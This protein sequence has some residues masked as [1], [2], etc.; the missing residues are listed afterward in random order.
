[1]TENDLIME[2][3]LEQGLPRPTQVQPPKLVWLLYFD[4]DLDDPTTFPAITLRDQLNPTATAEQR[5]V[6]M[7][8]HNG[9]LEIAA[10]GPP[11]PAIIRIRRVAPNDYHYW[12]YR[13]G[14]HAEFERC[15]WILST[16]P[17]PRWARGRRWLII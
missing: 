6:V 15:D 8:H 7:H 5:A 4:V 16:F 17:N 2:L 14:T 12:V 1:M 11:L 10:A 9:T 13:Q 3:T